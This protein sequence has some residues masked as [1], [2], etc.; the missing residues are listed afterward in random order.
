MNVGLYSE[1]SANKF[2]FSTDTLRDDEVIVT[3]MRRRF[4]VIMT[5]SLRHV[6][7]GVN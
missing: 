3:S 4:G 7:A 6:S 1:Y 2:K 5:L